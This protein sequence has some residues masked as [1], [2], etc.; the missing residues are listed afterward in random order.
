MNQTFLP[1]GVKVLS[2]SEL[3]LGVKNL[4]EEAFPGV[5]VAGEVSNLSRPS[6]GHLYLTLK[7]SQAQLAALI[8]RGVAL[9]MRYDLHDGMEVIAFGR[10][11]LYA[12]HGKYQLV[13]E[14]IQPKGIGAQELALRQLKE[15]LF[16][17]GYFDPKRK[18]PLP[19]FPRR[20]G[21]VT[22]P[23]GAAVRDMVEILGRR[24]PAVEVWV[25]PVKVQG[26]GAAEEIAAAVQLFNQVGGVDVM[27]VGRGGGCAEDLGP[28]NE[29]WVARAMF[30][31]RIPVVS[32]VGHEIDVTIADLVADRRAL[33][34]SEAAELVVP[35]QAEMLEGLRVREERLHALLHQ[36]LERARGRLQELS[37]RRAFKFPLERIH[38][39]GQRVDELADRL[40]RTLEQRLVRWRE[41][42]QAQTAR[43]QNLSPLNV[44]GRGYS[45]TRKESDHQVVRRSDQVQ[46]GDRLVTLLDQGQ[47]ISRVEEC[48]ARPISSRNLKEDVSFRVER[49]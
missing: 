14:Q 20:V 28:F 13:V 21:L 48:Q 2:V 39:A 37:E 5:W 15:K 33:T 31:S 46:P 45:L 35:N 27:I 1:E 12:P 42:L 47:I 25:C 7:D 18:K 43:L 49:T 11:G 34:P 9:R 6:S 29:E 4:L 41:R 38:Q 30:A 16:R 23:T 8:W 32:A 17:L 40:R 44:L 24:W 22:S 3:T 36:R 26:E 10:L 19:M